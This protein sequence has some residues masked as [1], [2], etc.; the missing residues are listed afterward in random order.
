MASRLV[1]MQAQEWEAAAERLEVEVRVN[2]ADIH[3]LQKQVQDLRDSLRQQQDNLRAPG[4]VAPA[5]WRHLA[6]AS[7]CSCGLAASQL[8]C[9]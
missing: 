1:L 4:P 5:G 7:P 6:S 2:E 8:H 9:S 3:R